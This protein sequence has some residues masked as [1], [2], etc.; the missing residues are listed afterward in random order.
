MVR[1]HESNRFAPDLGNDASALRL[2]RDQRRRPP[3]TSLRSGTTHHCDDRRLLRA[4]EHLRRYR[5]RLIGQ[6]R[7]ESAC[8]VPLTYAGYLSGVSADGMGSRPNGM[9]LVEEKEHANAPPDESFQRCAACRA[10]AQLIPV[11]VG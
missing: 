5:A 3:C 2:L 10:A 6:R 11:G 8:D 7:L 1:E 9:A 4:V